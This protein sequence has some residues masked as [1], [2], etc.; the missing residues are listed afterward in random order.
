M[1]TVPEEMRLQAPTGEEGA[2]MT[3]RSRPFQTRTPAS[4]K[5]QSP[6]VDRCMRRTIRDDEEERRRRHLHRSLL[7]GRI[8]QQDMTE[9]SRADIVR[10]EQPACTQSALRLCANVVDEEQ[11]D[12]VIL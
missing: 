6:M 10:H 11:S 8:R 2:D 1:E 9:R 12:L 4:G 7:T 3:A 5:A